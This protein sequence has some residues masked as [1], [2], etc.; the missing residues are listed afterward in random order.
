[1][2][3]DAWD[4]RR[5][6]RLAG[7]AASEQVAGDAEERFRQLY[8]DHY[9]AIAGYALRRGSPGD[10]ADIVAETFL[11]A[12]N[13][14]ADVPSGNAQR[15]WLYAVARNVAANQRRGARRRERLVDRLRFEVHAQPVAMEHSPDVSSIRTAL[16]RLRP[17]DRELLC[18]AA[19]ENLAPAD[20]AAV[21]GC[22]PG[23]AKVRLHRARRRFQNELDD[24]GV[25]DRIQKSF[26][27]LP[28][29]PLGSWTRKEDEV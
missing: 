9:R 16:A 1:M 18:L 12:W 3:T 20:I 5:E 6:A 13:R 2:G 7:A 23:A 19:W 26:S 24:L 14:L 11:V 25:G 22:S 4:D 29:V 27:D 8:S 10:A 21:V 17:A 15:R 28:E